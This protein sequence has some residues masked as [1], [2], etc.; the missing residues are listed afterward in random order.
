MVSSMLF[1]SFNSFL[2]NSQKINKNYFKRR[3]IDKCI[4]KWMRKRKS[5][6]RKK[7][8]ARYVLRVNNSKIQHHVSGPLLLFNQ[9]FTGLPAGIYLFKVNNRNTRTRCKIC[10]KLTLKIP[11]RRQSLLLTLNI[12]HTL[13][14]C[15]YW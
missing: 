12:F 6:G 15:F 11:E 7:Q 9:S 13:F 10:S 4:H 2:L 3:Q 5:K 14:Q 1:L 8:F